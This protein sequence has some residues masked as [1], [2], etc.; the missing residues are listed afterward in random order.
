MIPVARKAAL[1]SKLA[2]LAEK[3]KA[4]SKAAD[5]LKRESAV[6]DAKALAASAQSANDRVVV[7]VV[8]AGESREALQAAVKTVADACPKAAVMVFSVVEG[9]PGKVSIV[10]NV[11]PDLVGKLKA[12][13][14]VRD[15]A[16]V[17][18]GKGGGRPDQAQGGGTD[19]TKLRDSVA[20]AR[21]SGLKAVM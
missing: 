18:G 1:R 7:G 21:S 13:D 10:A 2:E 4:A 16:A 6:R 5:S 17:L 20:L 9:T 8:D 11:P 15:A 3:V 19:T 14:W 12:G